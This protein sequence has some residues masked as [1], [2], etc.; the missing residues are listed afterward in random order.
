MTT[1]QSG[2]FNRLDCFASLAMTPRVAPLDA[3]H[4]VF[5]GKKLDAI[6]PPRLPGLRLQ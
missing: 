6:E 2:C 1:K 5:Q 4:R 3:A